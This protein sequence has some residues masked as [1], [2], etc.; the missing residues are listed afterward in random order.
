MINKTRS[1]KSISHI[2]HQ[3]SSDPRFTDFQSRD[4]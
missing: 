3:K 2:T 4:T 1:N